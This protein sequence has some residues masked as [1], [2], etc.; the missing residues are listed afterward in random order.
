MDITSAIAA[1]G[2]MDENFTRAG[3][4]FRNLNNFKMLVSRK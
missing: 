2:D 1:S 3:S 4:R